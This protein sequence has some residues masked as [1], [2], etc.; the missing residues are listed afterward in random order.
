[1]S[2]EHLNPQES[3]QF[4]EQVLR[5]TAHNMERGA[6]IPFLIWGHLSVFIAL[7]IYFIL[8]YMGKGSYFLWFAIFLGVPL[9]Y[10]CQKKWRRSIRTAS[11]AQRVSGA[12]WLVLGIN[13]SLYGI[14][15]GYHVLSVVLLLMGIGTT[16]TGIIFRVKTLIFSGLIGNSFG[17]LSFYIGGEREQ[18]LLFAL[19]FFLMQCIPGYFLTYNALKSRV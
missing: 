12:L 11:L 8:P 19:G 1:M 3:V 10:L 7:T 17:Y 13:A 2:S 4:I 15:I 5:N 14:F 16:V 6:W 9:Q 18:L